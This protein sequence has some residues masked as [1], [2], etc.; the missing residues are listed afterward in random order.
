MANERT[1]RERRA[2][3]TY[4]LLKE[5]LDKLTPEQLTQPVAWSGDERGGY[6]KYVW[7]AEEDLVGEPSDHETW[8]PRS[9]VGTAVDAND[10]AD[11]AVCLPAGTVHL[12]VD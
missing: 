1:S 4:A 2:A 12:M 8:V 3:M 10:Y 6:V 9:D 5:Q 11:A 7:I